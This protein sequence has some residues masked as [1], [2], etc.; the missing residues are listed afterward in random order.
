[1]R[2]DAERVAVSRLW[3]LLGAALALFMYRAAGFV[4]AVLRAQAVTIEAVTEAET[5]PFT[6]EVVAVMVPESKPRR[7]FLYHTHTFEAYEMD[8]DNRYTPTET[9]RTADERCNVVR[10]GAELAGQLRAAGIEVTHD[11]TAFEPP[12]LS[13]AY[14]RSLAALEQ[15]AEEGYDLYIDLHRDSYS[16]GNGPNTVTLEGYPAARLLILIG[17][18]TGSSLEEKPDWETNQRVAQALSGFLNAR[19]EGLCRGVSLK[20]GRYNQQAATPSLL[21]EV[22]NNKNTLPEA[23]RAMEPLARAICQYFDALE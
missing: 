6:L 12:R 21:I 11:K 9:W 10:V 22:G 23:L 4:P 14:S 18:G 2:N 17:Q 20:S 19:C 13:T 16:K 7:V 8:D 5:A 1:M 3:L 15:A